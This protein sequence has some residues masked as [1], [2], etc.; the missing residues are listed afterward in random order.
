SIMRIRI[1]EEPLTAQNFSTIVSALTELYTKFWL[2]AKGRFV[3]L[4]DYTQTRDPRFSQEAGLVIA[5]ITHNSPAD[6]NLKFDFEGAAKALE[7]GIDAVLEAKERK[8]M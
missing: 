1:L 7:T 3:D 5:K 4:L 2:M 8:R 6:L